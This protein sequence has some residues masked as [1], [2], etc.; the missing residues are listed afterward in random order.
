MMQNTQSRVPRRIRVRAPMPGA[1]AGGTFALAIALAC[2]TNAVAAAQRTVTVVLSEE[3]DIL[4]PCQSSRSNIGRV[5][6]QNIVETLTE[7]NPKDGQIQPRL[8]TA[9]QQVDPNTWR[10][11]LREGVKF[12]DGAVL[13]A[14]AVVTSIN[15]TMNENIECEIRTKFFGGLKVTPRAVDAT[16]LEV[17]TDKPAPILPTMMGT[18]AVASPNSPADKS[19]N[20]PIG[21]GPYVLEKWDVGQEIVLSRFAGYWGDKPQAEQARYVWRTESTVR[22]AMVKTG[23]ADIAANIAVQDAT[24]PTMDFSYP[25]S[26]TSRMRID[27]SRPPLGDRRVRLAINHAIDRN[28]IRGSIFSPDVLPAT[29]LV[30]PSINGHN[31]D[32]EVWAYD[33]DKA[34]KLLA[35]A[36]AD[37]VPV[38]NEIVMIGRI[39]I[40]PNATEVMEAMHAMLQ[41]VGLNVTLRMVEVA[42]WVDILT[43]P[44]ADDRPPVLLQS[45][46]DNNNGDAVFT[47]Y[48]KYHSEGANSMLSDPK[49]DGVIEA[50]EKAVGDER[51]KLWQEAFR[52]IHEDLVA[53]V[54]MFHMVG[55]TRVGSRVNFVPNISTNSELHIEDVTFK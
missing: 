51:R 14:A 15:R 6:K 54:P 1:L 40:Y 23:E 53:D 36:K 10:F 29:Q 46:H 39:N 27:V 50:A 47:V 28:A 22:A 41:S 26:E 3:P 7:I 5:I 37:G 25:N 38:D 11:T 19:T 8:A 2:A 31:P 48:N 52:I 21:T 20:K 34:M 44:Y 9:W 4:E 43:K 16:T 17:V 24:D 45:Q 42:E 18:M 33:P 35:Q 49:L 30:V 32:L 12:H 13:D 55:Y